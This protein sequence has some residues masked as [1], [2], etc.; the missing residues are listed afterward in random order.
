MTTSIVPTIN[1]DM[2]KFSP[3]QLRRAGELLGC[4]LDEA[5]ALKALIIQQDTGLSITRGEISIVPFAGK[6]TVMINKQGYLA[7]A[8]RQPDYDGYESGT[9]RDG[10]EL[11]AWC[12]VYSKTRDKPTTV[13]IYE[14]EFKKESSPIW[15]EKPRYMLEKTA[16]SLA[17]RAAYP[18]LN[19]TY[20]EEEITPQERVIIE[21]KADDIV[22]TASPAPAP[23]QTIPQDIPKPK[24]IYSL[25]QA[26][27]CM[28]NMESQ[29]MDISVFERAKLP[30]GTFNGDMI[31]TEFTRQMKA[32]RQAASVC[33][34]GKPSMTAD[35]L[36]QF[37]AV[38]DGKPF[39]KKLCKECAQKL[40]EEHVAST[41]SASEE[42]SDVGFP[43]CAEC[44]DRRV[45]P[46]DETISRDKYGVPLCHSCLEKRMIADAQKAAEQKKAIEN[47]V[48]AAEADNVVKCAKCGAPLTESEVK[49]NELLNKGNPPLCRKCQT[50]STRRPSSRQTKQSSI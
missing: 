7:Y 9:E 42:S 39:D 17:L 14:S 23:V 25:E 20:T 18:I 48:T 24:K 32:K 44:G 36:K 50:A 11:T 40:W 3:E 19:G 16:I 26:N 15:K 4:K 30:D 45:L 27:S 46:E 43:F 1:S 13:R 5:S 2:Q 34:C 33:S 41:K 6:P 21:P 29:G 31:D 47:L 22:V 38:M 12:T 49:Q 28:S 35:E 37:S 10:D 8:T